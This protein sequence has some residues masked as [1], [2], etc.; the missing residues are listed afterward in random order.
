MGILPTGNKIEYNAVL[1]PR[2][3]DMRIVELWGVAD[4]MILMMQ[5]GME[6]KPK[7]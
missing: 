2:F 5:L 1:T 3:F 6:L 4:M 7:E